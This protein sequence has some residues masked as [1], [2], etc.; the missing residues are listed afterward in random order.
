MAWE[1][2]TGAGR[3]ED[4]RP[5]ILLDTNALPWLRLGDRRLGSNARRE[6]ERAWRSNE[7]AVSAIPFREG[8][9][10]AREPGTYRADR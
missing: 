2:E 4:Q 6:M 8:G 1:A 9:R 10:R 5:L 7:V 3:E